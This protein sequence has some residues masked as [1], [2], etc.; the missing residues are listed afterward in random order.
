MEV[1]LKAPSKIIL[2]GE[3]AVVYG[4]KAVAAAIALYTN[5]DIRIIDSS[6]EVLRY[7]IPLPYKS[8]NEEI[9]LSEIRSLQERYH[10]DR[11]SF[12]LFC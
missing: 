4:Y 12:N 8:K 7:D 6:T 2:F 5:I 11:T 9:P 1:R 3:H 10:F